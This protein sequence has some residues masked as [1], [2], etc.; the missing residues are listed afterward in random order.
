MLC[1]PFT[2]LYRLVL[3][4][5]CYMWAMDLHPQLPATLGPISLHRLGRQHT[6]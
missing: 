6:L 1:S 4:G 2:L 5:L 3:C